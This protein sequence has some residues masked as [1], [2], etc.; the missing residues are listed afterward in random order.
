MKLIASQD[1]KHSCFILL[2]AE[3]GLGGCAGVLEA[4][5]KK[6]TAAFFLNAC[7]GYLT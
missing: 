7:V 1:L 2:T 5:A 6:K 3:N 4:L